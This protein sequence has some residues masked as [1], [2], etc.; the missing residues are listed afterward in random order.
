[1]TLISTVLENSGA[2]TAISDVILTR[3]TEN[4]EISEN[5][6]LNPGRI[7]SNKVAFVGHTQK[8]LLI[9]R[10]MLFQWAGPALL[11]RVAANRLRQDTKGFRSEPAAWVHKN[12]ADLRLDEC[13]FSFSWLHDSKVHAYFL[14]CRREILAYGVKISGGTGAF[15]LENNGLIETADTNVTRGRPSDGLR[16]A[17]E[18]VAR[19]LMAELGYDDLWAFRFGGWYELV[20]RGGNGFE[21][22]PYVVV[23]WNVSEKGFSPFGLIGSRYVKGWLAID[24]ILPQKS[25]YDA[26]FW[27]GGYHSTGPLPAKA[28]GIP[29]GP[30]EWPLQIHIFLSA[31]SRGVFTMLRKRVPTDFRVTISKSKINYSMAES[32]AEEVVG[33]AQAVL[34]ISPAEATR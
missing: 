10:R 25:T 7:H 16:G 24:R 3:D 5:W 30:M 28:K 29:E 18:S 33:R 11:A 2:V 6:P 15:F 21:K 27:I 26:C 14:N 13:Q 19:C 31:D 9:N 34:G 12:L 22:I 32:F 1:M 20:T 17:L 4:N 23:L 8:S